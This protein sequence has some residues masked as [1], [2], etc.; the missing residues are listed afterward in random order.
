MRGY[1]D[2]ISV[3]KIQGWAIDPSDP[4]TPV[5]IRAKLNSEVIAEVKADMIREDVAN[6]FNT[7]GYHG[8]RFTG[9][10]IESLAPSDLKKIT[11]EAKHGDMWHQLPVAKKVKRAPQYQSFD[12]APGSSESGLKL[13]A[14]RLHAMSN[15]H[16]KAAPLKDLSVLDIGCNEG[17]FCHEA[18]RQGAKRVVGIDSKHGFIERAKTRTPEAEFIL[19]SWWNLPNERFDVILFLSAIHYEPRQKDYLTM[20]TNHLNP[21]GTLVL[22]CGVGPVSGKMWYTVERGDGIKRYPSFEMLC[23]ELLDS[24]TVRHAGK[25]VPQKGDPVDR[26]VYHCCLKRSTALIIIGPE[27]TGKTNLAFT[28]NKSGIPV[29]HI[30]RLLARILSQ[31]RYNWSPISEIKK[32]VKN[33]LAMNYGIICNQIVNAGYAKKLAQLIMLECPL[34]SEL[35]VIEGQALQHVE[36]RKHLLDMLHRDG[37]KT[38]I[39]S[40]DHL[41]K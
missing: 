6:A 11:V 2:Q 28:L 29:F 36:L 39:V 41:K 27:K 19:D 16:S 38:W 22:E 18:V 15:S 4:S 35:F 32:Q 12:D 1:I 14:I 24:Y 10:R 26:H 33:E 34:E 13:K 31:E 37:I 21:G 5:S 17:F 30:D 8:F 3:F 20:L 9:E 25:S 23:F 40:A 7:K